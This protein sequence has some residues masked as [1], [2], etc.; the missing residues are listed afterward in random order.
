MSVLGFDDQPLAEW[1][2][3]TTVAQSPSEMGRVAGDLVLR[4]I[5]DPEADHE[6]H[7]VLPTRLIPRGTTAPPSGPPAQDENPS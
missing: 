3:L 4:L 2:D 7:I 5:N 1:F 6:R